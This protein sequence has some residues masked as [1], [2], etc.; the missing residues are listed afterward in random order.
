MAGLFFDQPR[1]AAMGVK[2]VVE[3]MRFTPDHHEAATGR[4]HDIHGLQH[5]IALKLA[6]CIN[7]LR[8]LVGLMGAEA[9]D[10]NVT[11]ITAAIT[12]LS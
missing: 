6:E 10:A 9:S 3:G 12:Q 7:G 8:L 4:G 11:T 2:T 1:E 5:G